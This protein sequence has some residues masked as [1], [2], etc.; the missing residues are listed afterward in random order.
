MSDDRPCN[1]EGIGTVCIKMFEG[2]VWE[3]KEMRHIP[4]LK[5]NLFSVD[6]LKALGHGVS[7]RDGI[8]KMIRDSMVVLQGV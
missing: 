5:M 8:L 3:L 7:V 6:A 2:M 4:Q 1:T